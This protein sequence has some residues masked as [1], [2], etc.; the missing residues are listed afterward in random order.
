MNDG[1][2]LYYDY[3]LSP[4]G[5][6]YYQT[7][8]SQL[9][10]IENKNVLDFGSGFGFTADFLAEK[11]NVTAVEPD[12]NIIKYAKN[13]NDYIQI[14]ASADYLKTFPDGSFDFIT[15]HLVLEFADNRDQIIKELTRLVKP[16][17]LISIIHHNRHGRLIQAVVQD[18]DIEEAARMF[19][20]RPSFSS[21]FGDINYYTAD[22]LLD[23]SN[24][25]LE[26]KSV[27]GIRAI[28]SLHD[29]RR[30]SAENWLNEMQKIED[31]LTVDPDFIKIS[32]FN[33]LLLKKR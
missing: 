22:D 15:C 20:G 3:I 11:N 33:H 6:L 29:S 2:K 19:D 8:F 30:Q 25:K 7:V 16:E 23:L 4:I 28:A 31:K 12:K 21:A 17:G 10:T 13:E 24:N 32:Y 27:F 5:K 1:M 26:I 14:N 9:Q 18:F